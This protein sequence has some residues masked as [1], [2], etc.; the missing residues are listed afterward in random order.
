M[1]TSMANKSFWVAGAFCA[2]AMNVNTAECSDEIPDVSSYTE[3]PTPT[4]LS[5]RD[6][7]PKEDIEDYMTR[8]S[9]LVDNE[10]ELTWYIRTACEQRAQIN[11]ELLGKIDDASEDFINIKLEEIIDALKGKIKQYEYKNI[12]PYWRRMSLEG[13]KAL[14][15]IYESGVGI[16]KLEWAHPH[17]GASMGCFNK[18][19]RVFN[20]LF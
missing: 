9:K 17:P 4:M 15:L 11:Q 1:Y 19:R 16:E 13:K 18:Q 20:S 7:G 8:L 10:D 6:L 3:T 14:C 12:T 5:I 2:L